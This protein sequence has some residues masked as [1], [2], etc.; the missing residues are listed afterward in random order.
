MKA[1]KRSKEE[2]PWQPSLTLKSALPGQPASSAQSYMSSH[3]VSRCGS[4][5]PSDDAFP[6]TPRPKDT[7]RPCREQPGWY[8][9]DRLWPS[10]TQIPWD[11]YYCFAISTPFIIIILS[12]FQYLLGSNPYLWLCDFMPS[13]LSK[14]IYSFSQSVALY[15]WCLQLTVHWKLCFPVSSTRT[16]LIYV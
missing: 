9:P 5:R 3:G 4:C 2:V 12:L 7:P 10:K 8:S 16:Q 11:W 15:E 6:P 1:T 14:L 13:S